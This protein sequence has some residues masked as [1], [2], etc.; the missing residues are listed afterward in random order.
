VDI[1]RLYES[2]S[3]NFFKFFA[4]YIGERL[5]LPITTACECNSLEW[6]G[7]IYCLWV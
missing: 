6:Y 3:E 4:I 2:N 7:K 5:N 1:F